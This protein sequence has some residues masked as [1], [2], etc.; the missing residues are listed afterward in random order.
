MNRT[1]LNRQCL[2]TFLFVSQIFA[3]GSADAQAVK[4]ELY[5]ISTVTVTDHQFLTGAK[6]GTPAVIAG[7]FAF[8]APAPIG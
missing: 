4:T 7:E 6:D 3:T 8:R 5:P 2:W 1:T